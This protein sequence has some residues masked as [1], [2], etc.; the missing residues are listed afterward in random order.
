MDLAHFQST[1]ENYESMIENY[2]S[3]VSSP[4]PDNNWEV[5]LAHLESQID[6]T[7]AAIVV[8]NPSNPC[9]SV[10][11]REHLR[12]IANIAVK[13][14]IPVIADEIYDHFVS[15]GDLGFYSK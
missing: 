5:D 6:P 13:H 14:K 9:G 1:I 3:Y 7:T 15:T 2:V 11:S 10:F 4:Q 12:D 8:N